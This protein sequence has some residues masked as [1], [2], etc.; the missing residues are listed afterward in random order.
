MRKKDW[1]HMLSDTSVCI[2][3][4]YRCTRHYRHLISSCFIYSCP[5]CQLALLDALRV[6]T[7]VSAEL[8]VQCAQEINREQEL[9]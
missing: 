4:S 1:Q 3:A 9:A 5:D 7:Q 6:V 2:I 8:L